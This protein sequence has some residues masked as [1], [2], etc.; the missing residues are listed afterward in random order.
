MSSTP[1]L[2]RIPRL[3]GRSEIATRPGLLARA[4]RRLAA[5][6]ATLARSR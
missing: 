5:L 2:N 3:P 4:W 6:L 1:R